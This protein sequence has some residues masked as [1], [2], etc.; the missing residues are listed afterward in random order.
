VS[1]FKPETFGAL[2]SSNKRAYFKENPM[3]NTLILFGLCLTF[4]IPCLAAALTTSMDLDY[5]GQSLYQRGLYA[6]AIGYYQMA[7][8]ADPNNAQAYQDMGNAY[9]KLNDQAN[10]LMA[11]QKSLALN[12]DNPTLKVMVDNMSANTTAP[13]AAPQAQAPAPSN[14]T[15]TVIEEQPARP[16]LRK[17]I[18]EE[19]I[20]EAKADRNPNIA[21]IDQ[22]KAWIKLELGYN[23]AQQGDLINSANSINNGQFNPGNAI[24]GSLA[25]TGSALASNSGL[26]WGGEL[27]FL[28]SPNF[29]LAIG[30][31]YIQ[32]N[33]Y[34]ANVVYDTGD[35]ENLTLTPAVVPLTLDLYFFLPDKGGRFFL[36]AGTGYYLGMVH[37]DQTTTSNNFFG[38]QTT[39][40]GLS[41]DEWTGDMY[42]G[43][44]GFQFGI[45][46]EFQVS[47]RFG[48]E[49]FARAYY[50]Q[51]SN[52][53]G[54][55]NDGNS[56]GTFAL[57]SSSSG[58][59]LVDAENP[60]L[61]NS[62]Y[63]ERY[64]TIDF[65]GFDVGASLNFYYF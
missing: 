49:L 25:Y 4:F 61:V 46:R 26:G 12:P 47:P 6:K 10:A 40:P 59:A 56:S 33:D 48:I 1:V 2:R 27:G 11:Y 62:T 52:F 8:Q 63:Q 65:T 18:R 55:L 54:T 5:Q 53:Q 16:Y 32:S 15:T 64:A 37:V 60:A 24:P 35:L 3:K 20:K 19:Q 38:T 29:G 42:S 57:A 13:A 30:S 50:A 43:N 22:A 28:L 36:S 23:Y 31:R 51:I 44:I 9:M 41:S 7:V 21:A 34:K 45:G 58:P 17:R 14:N 39:P